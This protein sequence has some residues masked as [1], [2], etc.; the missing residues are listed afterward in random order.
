MIYNVVNDTYPSISGLKTVTEPSAFTCLSFENLNKF[1]KR[2]Q[3]LI[4]LAEVAAKQKAFLPVLR[5]HDD[6]HDDVM[7][8]MN[9][10]GSS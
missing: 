2:I 7:S 9:R 6:V 1:I 10:M 4:R 3:V 5:K 8:M